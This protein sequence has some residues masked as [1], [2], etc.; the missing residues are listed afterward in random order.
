METISNMGLC[1]V[2]FPEMDVW[3]DEKFGTAVYHTDLPIFGHVYIS[4]SRGE[5]HS[6]EEAQRL[7]R[8]YYGVK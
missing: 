2:Q 5:E 8:R 4:F 6:L 3:T 7:I 1:G